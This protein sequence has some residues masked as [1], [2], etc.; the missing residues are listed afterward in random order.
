MRVNFG[1]V[2]LEPVLLGIL[3]GRV[4]QVANHLVDVVLQRGDFARRFD[5]DRTRQIALR[6]GRRHF[7]DGAHLS[8]Q[9][10]RELVHV[11]RQIPPVPAAPGTF[12]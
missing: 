5:G 10:C 1:Q 4:L 3:L 12:A 7:R 2:R 8:R 11:V 6:H 9:V